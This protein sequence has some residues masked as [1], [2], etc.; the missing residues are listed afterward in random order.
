MVI[1]SNT[2]EMN[3]ATIKNVCITLNNWTPDEYHKLFD[4]TG[5]HYI[6]I[7]KEI[8]ANG[9]PHLQAFGQL[10]RKMRF[11]T[12]K[13]T[14]CPRAHIEVARGAA[15]Q[16]RDYCKK[17]TQSHEEWT[18]LGTQGPNF[19]AD[20]QF[21]ERGTLMRQGERSDLSGAVKTLLDSRSLR[22]V[23]DEHPEV[24]VRYNR[25]LQ[26]LQLISNVGYEHNVCRGIW[27]HGPPGSGKS[28]AVR[29]MFPNAYIKP[30]NKW[31]DGYDGQEVVLLDDMDTERL[32]H[33]LKIWAD[34]YKCTGETKGSTVELSYKKFIVTSNKSI[35]DLFTDK[36]GNFDNILVR[37]VRRRFYEQF[38]LSRDTPVDFDSDSYFANESDNIWT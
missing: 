22:A 4:Y 26:A 9:T 27:I 3:P 31:W 29:T 30:Q 23:A 36:F 18:N 10:E 2:M 34:K 6:I 8:G 1:F 13:T 21:E 17:G 28:H 15:E 38:K 14:V 16:A 7:G 12:F 24:Y 35:K 25:G 37:A 33:L 5:W 32:G 19:G 11:N 20:V